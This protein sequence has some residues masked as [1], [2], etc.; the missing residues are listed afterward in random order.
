MPQKIFHN[1]LVAIDKSKVTLTLN[2]PAY[3]V[4]CILD[5]SIVLMPKFHYDSIKNR[6]G[7]NLRLL[8]TDTDGLMYEIKTEDFYDDFSKNKE[9]FLTIIH[10][11]KYYDHSNKLVVGNMKDNTAGVAIKEF[12][13]LKPKIYQILVDDNSE[14]EKAKGVNKNFVEKI[15]HDEYKYILLNRK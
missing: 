12:V 6:F 3:V 5:L 7:N 2:K 13:G 8:F 10:K 1:D 4:L 9:P 11:S 14:H 15:T